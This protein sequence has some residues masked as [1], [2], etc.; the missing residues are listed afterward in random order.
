MRRER[1]VLSWKMRLVSSLAGAA[2]FTA[3]IFLFQRLFSASHPAKWWFAQTFWQVF[4]GIYVFSFF[5]D[6]R[7]L[8]TLAEKSKAAGTLPS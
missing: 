1:P 5:A 6:R 7:R 2:S 8:R 3:S 4:V